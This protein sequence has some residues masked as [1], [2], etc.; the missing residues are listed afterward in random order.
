MKEPGELAFEIAQSKNDYG[1]AEEW[2][3]IRADAKA[4]WAALE[5][6]IR[7]DEAAKVREECATIADIIAED[8]GRPAET[9]AAAIRALGSKK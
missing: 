2:P 7:A 1:L 8:Y 5:S 3:L 6:T 4:Y 9:V